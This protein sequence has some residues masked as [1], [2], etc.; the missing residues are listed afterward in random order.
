VK[1]LAGSICPPISQVMRLQSIEHD[2][3]NPDL[4]L[5]CVMPRQNWRSFV[6]QFQ[7]FS[8]AVPGVCD[9]PTQLQIEP[10]VPQ[11]DSGDRHQV[12]QIAVDAQGVVQCVQQ[13]NIEN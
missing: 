5:L 4:S 6:S 7:Q 8:I 10:E 11:G 1:P 9:P 3:E 12:R 13:Q 2:L